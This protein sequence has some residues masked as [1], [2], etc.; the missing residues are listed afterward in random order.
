M[1]RN[2]GLCEKP[3]TVAMEAARA[4]TMA[5]GVTVRYRLHRTGDARR[6]LVLLHGLAS[7]LT[8]WSEFVS[9]TALKRSWDILRLDLRGHGQSLTRTRIGMEPWCADLA[10]ILEAEG[11]GRAVFVG[12]SL[13]ANLAV[14]F[15]SRHP[16][17]VLA[18]ALIDPVLTDA[19][20]GRARWL[21]RLHPLL[22]FA[23]VVVRAL[24]AL[25]LRRRSFP[26]L[27]LASLDEE[28][29]GQLLA[30]GKQAEFI[31]RY[32]STLGDLKYFP[33]ANYLQEAIELF[34]PLPPLATIRRPILA[35]IS[36]G[37]TFTKLEV[38]RRMFEQHPQAEVELI[39]AYHW[40]LTEKPVEVREAIERWCARLAFDD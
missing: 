35:L 38:T 25:G 10:A 4:L 36:K 21:Y 13:G 18:L 31:R 23:I 6:V 5:D 8:R 40:P 17:R 39:D 28:V 16:D 27:D 11:Y 2:E 29:R 20:E 15:G 9:H 19:V 1:A 12:H 33:T 14:H 26:I 32:S 30:A 7:N 3:E 24:N 22:R 37:V 34:S